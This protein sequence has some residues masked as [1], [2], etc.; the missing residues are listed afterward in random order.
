MTK[1]KSENP[2][3]IRHHESNR[4]M[5]GD[6]IIALV[7]LYFMAYFYY[8]ARSL[9]LGLTGVAAA[10][11]TDIIGNFI[12]GRR[13]NPRDYSA[14]AT[15]LILPLLMPATVP[16]SILITA[17]IFGIAVAKCP[18]GG[19]GQ[20]IFNP[21]AAGFAFVA[22]CWPVSIFSYPA[23]FESI[24]MSG[25]I[26]G[27][28]VQS[29]AYTMKVGGIPSYDHT[30]LLFGSF[31]GP[32]GATNILV[33]ITCL[34]FLLFRN[35]VRFHLPIGFFSSVALCALLFPRNGMDGVQSVVF[36]MCS[37]MLLFVGVYM[38]N[39]PVTSPKRDS[40]KLVYG[41]LAGICTMLFRRIGGFEESVVFA[42]LF[43]NVFSSL[44]DILNER[45]HHEIRARRQSVEARKQSKA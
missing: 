15:G 7:P 19:F 34:L 44:I 30:E 29:M 27:K 21:A 2:P 12:L 35:T 1:F 20:N 45:I 10:L 31:A 43:M 13:V 11:I 36:E 16:Y 23:P 26:T 24:S 5:V 32:M 38:L 18:F 25:A 33:I 17:A 42:L 6:V 28:L 9:L 8:G 4:T 41:V 3:H 14:I 22:I 37:G 40:S 39:D